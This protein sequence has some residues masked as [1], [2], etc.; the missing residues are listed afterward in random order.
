MSFITKGEWLTECGALLWDVSLKDYCPFLPDVQPLFHMSCLIFGNSNGCLNVLPF[1]SSW[2][3]A[4][5][6]SFFL[7]PY[8]KWVNWIKSQPKIPNCKCSWQAVFK[9]VLLDIPHFYYHYHSSKFNYDLN[10]PNNYLLRRTKLCVFCLPLHVYMKWTLYL[11]QFTVLK[12][13]RPHC[14]EGKIKWMPADSLKWGD[15]AES[16]VSWSSQDRVT[17][18]REL[19]TDLQRF[20]EGP[21]WGFCW[22][23]MSACV[24][25]NYPRLDKEPPERIR[26]NSPLAESEMVPTLNSHTRN[27]KV[28]GHWV[29]YTKG[30]SS[31]LGI[32]EL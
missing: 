16:L 22:V 1:V 32:N 3:E 25:E 27:L 28:Q 13:S 30:F 20:V 11:S 29:E 2:P 15:K 21:F 31:V 9:H 8:F 23:L 7:Y 19:C 24:W 17:E 4:K 18:R 10:Y 12:V 14:R 26:G 5:S 6:L